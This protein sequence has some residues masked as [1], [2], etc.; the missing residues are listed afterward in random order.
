MGFDPP[1]RPLK[2]EENWIAIG[3]RSPTGKYHH[4]KSQKK[5]LIG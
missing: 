1:L 5:T 3:L 2:R 4:Q